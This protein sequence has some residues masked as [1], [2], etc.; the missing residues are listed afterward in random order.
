[1]NLCAYITILCKSLWLKVLHF[2]ECNFFCWISCYQPH[3]STSSSK[4]L[5]AKQHLFKKRWQIK[6]HPLHSNNLQS[7]QNHN[8]TCLEYIIHLFLS[9]VSNV[10]QFC[11][12]ADAACA[13]CRACGKFKMAKL[14]AQLRWHHAVLHLSRS[15]V[16]KRS[17]SLGCWR[18]TRLLSPLSCHLSSLCWAVNRLPYLW[19]CSGVD[20]CP[21]S[22]QP[23]LHCT[24]LHHEWHVCQ[25]GS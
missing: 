6:A 18:V 25:K 15:W 20:C 12:L 8:V 10:L 3:N 23:Q 5:V 22:P 13:S 14:E 2:Q 7:N 19:T 17:K 4:S 16:S 21:L 1:M 9:G 24:R 11:M